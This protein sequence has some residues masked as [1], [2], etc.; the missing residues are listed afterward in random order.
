MRHD[1]H[2]KLAEEVDTELSLGLTVGDRGYLASQFREVELAAIRSCTDPSVE[3]VGVESLMQMVRKA[4]AAGDAL[5]NRVH[6]HTPRCNYPHA[7]PS[8]RCICGA[9]GMLAK[10]EDATKDILR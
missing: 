9:D 7:N 10:W 5:A 2:D 6:Q 3:Y 1:K 8:N 4:V